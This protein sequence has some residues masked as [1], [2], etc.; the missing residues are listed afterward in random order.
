MRPDATARYF[1][2]RAALYDR[3]HGDRSGLLERLWWRPLVVY[4]ER[5]LQELG[6]LRGRRILEVGCGTGHLAVEMAR[7][8]ASVVALDLSP[9]MIDLAR[10]HA[11]A[12]GV[13]DRLELEVADFDQ[14]RHARGVR[15]DCAVALATFEY[16]TA[17]PRWIGAFA[18]LS[19][20]L[21]ATFPR[22]AP[23]QVILRRARAA[24]AG[25]LPM[26]F[27][28]EAEVEALLRAAGF[29]VRRAERPTSA[30]WVDAAR[31]EHAR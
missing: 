17:P 26:R 29:V 1:S 25:G 15:F 10:R 24:L 4:R 3:V 22:P 6:D 2:R 8:G 9:T 20:R 13:S 27:Y 7:R 12:S 23:S 28:S 14:W 19:E 31:A 30:L 11:E 16:C 21:I 18:A 5:T